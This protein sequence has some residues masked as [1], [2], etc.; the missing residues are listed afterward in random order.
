M[1]IFAFLNYASMMKSL[2]DGDE[3][4]FSWY[5]WVESIL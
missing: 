5:Q 4:K 3:L 1:D 2:Y